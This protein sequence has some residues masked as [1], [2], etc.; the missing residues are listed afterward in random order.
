MNNLKN[1]FRA[2]SALTGITS[3]FKSPNRRFNRKAP[4]S[5]HTTRPGG[6]VQD[7]HPDRVKTKGGSK[8]DEEKWGAVFHY[9]AHRK[10]RKDRKGFCLALRS[11]IHYSCKKNEIPCPL[12]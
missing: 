1:I 4:A 11:Y 8:I 7:G 2:A 5:P 6:A 3:N 12:L 9:L 10:G